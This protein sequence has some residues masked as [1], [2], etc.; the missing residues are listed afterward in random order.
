MKIAKTRKIVLIAVSAIAAF[1]LTVAIVIPAFT[2]YLE[3]YDREQIKKIEK[4]IAITNQFLGIKE[5]HL[6]AATLLYSYYER[7]RDYD[8]KSAEALSSVITESTEDIGGLKKEREKLES[9]K[10]VNVFIKIR[11][12][13]VGN[14]GTWHHDITYLSLSH[15]ITYFSLD[16]RQFYLSVM[17]MK[18]RAEIFS[19]LLLDKKERFIN[20][21]DGLALVSNIMKAEKILNETEKDLEVLKSFFEPPQIGEKI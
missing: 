2:N 11:E 21:E 15:N 3:Q 4:E 16:V 20:K 7:S 5:K 9:I 6:L 10:K 8:K 18:I 13:I 17:E 14:D 12:R 19:A 1:V